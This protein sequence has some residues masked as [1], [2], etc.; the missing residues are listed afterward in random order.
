MAVEGKGSASPARRPRG[1]SPVS[2]P[3]HSPAPRRGRPGPAR[4]GPARL[5]SAG[6]GGGAGS[7][8]RQGL[9][10][11]RRRRGRSAARRTGLAR[12]APG[13]LPRPWAR[14]PLRRRACPRARWRG[15]GPRPPA[16]GPPARGGRR[17]RGRQRGLPAEPAADRR[18]QSGN[19]P[20]GPEV[21]PLPAGAADLRRLPPRWP[22]RPRSARRASS[23]PRRRSPGGAEAPPS[24]GAAPNP[25]VPEAVVP[26]KLQQPPAVLRRGRRAVG[27]GARSAS[28]SPLGDAQAR[29]PRCPAPGEAGAVRGSLSSR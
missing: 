29:G 22:R 24:L 1:P 26:T 25:H 12:G 13:R 21:P 27:A 17:R 3:G 8:R 9:R 4:L 5:G 14:P 16:G 23:P 2:S 7:G 18:L 28:P 6:E 19:F 20:A 10:R 15:V 11:R